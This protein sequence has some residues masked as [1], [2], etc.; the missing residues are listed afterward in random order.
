MNIRKNIVEIIALLFVILFLYTGISKVMDYPV[1]KE[2]IATS[3]LLA[4]VS[5]WI[6][7]M[8]PLSEFVV[9]VLLVIPRWRLK[10]L[11]AALGLMLIF[12][13]YI[14]F[15]LNFNEQLPCSCGGVLEIL[16]WKAHLIFNGIFIAL[17]LAGIAIGK[18]LMQAK[19][20]PSSYS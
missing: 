18:R 2:Q 17:A 7:W 4:P 8:L 11:Y 1:F 15:I 6:S 14:I 13:G 16:S 5:R 10:G 20:L 12:T 9:T 19:E 3:P